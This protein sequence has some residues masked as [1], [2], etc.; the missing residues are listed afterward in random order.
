MKTDMDQNTSE[1][2]YD[3]CE[4]KDHSYWRLTINDTIGT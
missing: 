1:S 4:L 3:L 2:L